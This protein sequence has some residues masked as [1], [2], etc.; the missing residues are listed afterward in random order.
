MPSQSLF[1]ANRGLP[2]S[3]MACI[4]V[5]IHAVLG[6]QGSGTCGTRYLGIGQVLMA[7]AARLVESVVRLAV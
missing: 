3:I 7:D 1:K 4:K 6:T 2:L 5:P